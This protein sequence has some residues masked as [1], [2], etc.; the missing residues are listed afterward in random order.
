[1]D[2][3]AVSRALTT[4]AGEHWGR[5]VALVAAQFRRLDLAE[6]GVQDAFA[7]AAR[8]W[9]RSGVP[10][11]PPAWLLTAA[12]RRVLDALRTEATAHKY[13]PQLIVDA[14][15][16]A[17]AAAAIPPEGD[18]IADERLRLLFTCCHPA[19]PPSG[20]AALVL[21]LVAGLSVGEI[22]RLFLVSE[23]AM[24]ARLTRVKHKIA[25]AGI[26]FAVP[27]S[28]E[29]PARLDTVLAVI[30]L[31]FTEGYAATDGPAVMRTELADE[32]IR[33]G[34][35]TRRLLPDAPATRA[36]L[37]LMLLQHS[38]RDARVD[39]AGRPILLPDQDRSRWIR[40][41]IDEGLDLLAGL[42][43]VHL[44]PAAERYV[45]QAR[46]A[47]QHAAPA[48]A[49]DTNWPEIADLYERLERLTASP[50]VRLNRAVAVAEADG[51]DAALGLLDGLEATLPGRHEVHLVR[52]EL[53][54]R[55]GRRSDAL[56]A[57]DQAIAHAGN[58]ATRT[59]LDER[60]A[61]L[62][63]ERDPTR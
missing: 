25:A 52:A 60:R 12:R 11:N 61:A 10:T 4:V 31:V 34:R 28:D 8:H 62:G 47:A 38:R 63:D 22:A 48:A 36:L 13:A 6:D 50:V 41:E 56:T 51:A 15:T 55:S 17:V 2:D 20:S 46:I 9:P 32:A 58:D 45:L 7:A 14:R 33:L 23:T 29:L 19:L 18:E 30:Y 57:M 5:L 39:A 26:P 42:E 54:A 35:L 49:S 27:D 3:D 16:E 44:T 59:Y 1:M 24:Q 40:S 21:R 43:R 53:L 37:S